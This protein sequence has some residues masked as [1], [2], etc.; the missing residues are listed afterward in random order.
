MSDATTLRP[1]RRTVPSMSDSTSQL[2]RRRG[3]DT[4]LA[5]LRRSLSV[6]A[7]ILLCAAPNQAQ[8]AVS[9]AYAAKCPTCRSLVRSGPTLP[10]SVPGEEPRSYFALRSDKGGVWMSDPAQY[11]LTFWSVAGERQRTV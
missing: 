5:P 10:K 4:P 2:Q 3:T 8:Q 7:L 11:R 9:I 1:A 6:V